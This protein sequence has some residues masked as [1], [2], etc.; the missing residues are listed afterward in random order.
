MKSYNY[1]YARLLPIEKNNLTVDHF[2]NISPKYTFT[3]TF[4]AF[5]SPGKL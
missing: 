4:C 3:T 1:V 2:A 5:T